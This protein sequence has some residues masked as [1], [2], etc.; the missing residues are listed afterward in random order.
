LPTSSR[1]ANLPES[2]V[3]T[4]KVPISDASRS[5]CAAA[6][7]VTAAVSPRAGISTSS[8]NGAATASLSSSPR[9]MRT[10]FGGRFEIRIRETSSWPVLVGRGA[11]PLVFGCCFR[12]WT[13]V[14]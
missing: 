7:G 3:L 10:V 8:P 5:N 14:A 4:G 6:N 9:S 13:G 2:T 11:C 1:P 12:L